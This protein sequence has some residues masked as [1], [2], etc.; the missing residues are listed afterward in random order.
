MEIVEIEHFDEVREIEDKTIDCE[1]CGD[2]FVFSANEQEFFAKKGF[3]NPKRCKPCRNKRKSAKR[4]KKHRQ[5]YEAVCQRC[6]DITQ[7]PFKPDG[8]RVYCKSCYADR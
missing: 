8:K 3:Q 2:Q 1:D 6:S 5:L 4:V 7:V